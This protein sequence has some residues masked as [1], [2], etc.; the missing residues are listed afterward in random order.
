MVIDITEHR[1]RPLMTSAIINFAAVTSSPAYRNSPASI[2]LYNTERHVRI[3]LAS[4]PLLIKRLLLF[5]P[6][7][8]HGELN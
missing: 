8:R 4:L 5:P 2:K 1:S 3:R 6:E 7:F